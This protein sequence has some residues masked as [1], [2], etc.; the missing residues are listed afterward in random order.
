MPPAELKNC[1]SNTLRLLVLC[2]SLLEQNVLEIGSCIFTVC[3]LCYPIYMKLGIIIMQQ[4]QQIRQ[5][6]TIINRKIST[7]L[8][9]VGLEYGLLHQQGVLL[10]DVISHP[11]P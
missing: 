7:N 8:T 5:I 2:L 4:Q 11:Q 6:E 3:N 10:M 1:G 9:N